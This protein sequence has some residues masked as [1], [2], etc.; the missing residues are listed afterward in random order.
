MLY[1]GFVLGVI[2]GAHESGLNYTRFSASSLVL[3]VPALIGGRIWYLIGHPKLVAGR[4][5]IALAQDVGAGLYG[6]LVLS[7]IVSWPELRLTG[8]EFWRFWDGAAVVLLV[9]MMVTRIGCLMTGCCAGRETHGPF[10][11][12]LPDHVGEWNRRYP[13][14][15][16]EAGW[17]AAILGVGTWIYTPSEPPGALFLGAAAAYGF[18]R[19]GL[20]LLRAD[21]ASIALPTRINLA[22]SGLLVVGSLIALLPKIL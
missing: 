20:E 14:Q 12:W 18:G 8:L 22:F 6:G 13:T 1:V 7:F 11:M 9:G 17:S 16:L 3:L 15:L 4:A 19:L 10:G 5:G 21:A 2:Y